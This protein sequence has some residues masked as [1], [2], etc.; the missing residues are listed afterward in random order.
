M[1]VVVSFPTS[2]EAETRLEASGILFTNLG[3]CFSLK[4][5]RNALRNVDLQDAYDELARILFECNEKKIVPTFVEQHPVPK[6]F[7]YE[8]EPVGEATFPQEHFL[9]FFRLLK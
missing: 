8:G 2:E 9:S 5:M 4:I 1:G 3:S 6:W 7:G